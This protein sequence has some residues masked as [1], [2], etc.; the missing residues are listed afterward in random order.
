MAEQLSPGATAVEPVLWSP[1]T[2]A[3][4]AELLTKEASAMRSTRARLEGSSHSPQPEEAR[5]KQRR[6]SVKNKV[7]FTQNLI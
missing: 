7:F 6:P 3:P 4:E 5:A 2:A 1:G